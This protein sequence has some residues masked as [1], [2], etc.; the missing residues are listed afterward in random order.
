ME[1]NEV[2]TWTVAGGWYLAPT[3]LDETGR[4]WYTN[5]ED[6]LKYEQELMD[7]SDYDY[8]EVKAV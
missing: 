2:K 7:N 3:E 1:K 4:R 5:R 6:A 8:V